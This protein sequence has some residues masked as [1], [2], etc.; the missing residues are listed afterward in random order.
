MVLNLVSLSFA[1]EANADEAKPRVSCFVQGRRYIILGA[2]R[3]V[4]IAALTVADTLSVSCTV[5]PLVEI[6]SPT[7]ISSGWHRM[8]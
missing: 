1:E 3:R 2:D 8:W 6:G 7:R 4:S 5:N